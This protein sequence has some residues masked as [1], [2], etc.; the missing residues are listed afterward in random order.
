MS[1]SRTGHTVAELRQKN[2]H[3]GRVAVRMFGPRIL[4]EDRAD[5]KLGSAPT[6]TQ[7]VPYSRTL[8]FDSFDI[9]V[10]WR[11]NYQCR[12]LG[13]FGN[14][15]KE[16]FKS[17]PVFYGERGHDR[18]ARIEM[19]PPEIIGDLVQNIVLIRDE[20]RIEKRAALK[21]PISQHPLSEAMDSVNGSAVETLQGD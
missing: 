17:K 1:A 5:L 11:N 15:A 16:L 9:R 2:S 3:L 21:R 13:K 12:V 10:K 6:I 19:P 4:L 20:L 14:V 7:F 8:S 18:L